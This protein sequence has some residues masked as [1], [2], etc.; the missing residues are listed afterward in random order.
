MDQNKEHFAHQFFI[1]LWQNCI[2][3]TTSWDKHGTWEPEVLG[4]VLSPWSLAF[5]ARNWRNWV[6]SKKGI[7][8]IR[9]NQWKDGAGGFA[10]TIT[11][12]IKENPIPRTRKVTGFVKFWTKLAKKGLKQKKEYHHQILDF[13]NS[14]GAKFQIKLTILIFLLQIS[15]KRVFS[16]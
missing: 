6:F 1:C 13:R 10:I 7:R 9:N 16:L 12:T 5:L 14:L 11:A 4:S 8:R 2:N 3:D 15:P